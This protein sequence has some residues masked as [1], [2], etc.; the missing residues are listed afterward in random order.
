MADSL[1]TDRMASLYLRATRLQEEV[2][3][4]IKAYMPV[5]TLVT[6]KFTAHSQVYKGEVAAYTGWDKVLIKLKEPEMPGVMMPIAP[7]DI[8]A[9]TLQDVIPSTIRTRKPTHAKD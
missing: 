3:H 6:F 1:L 5:G 4:R 7:F 8:G 2:G 9:V